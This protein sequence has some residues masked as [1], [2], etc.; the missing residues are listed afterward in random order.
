MIRAEG[1][2]FWDF[3]IVIRLCMF[4]E[5]LGHFHDPRKSGAGFFGSV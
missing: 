1:V 5:K 4:R 2:Y 3:T